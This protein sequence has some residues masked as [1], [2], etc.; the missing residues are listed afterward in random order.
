MPKRRDSLSRFL[1]KCAVKAAFVYICVGVR[2]KAVKDTWAR[3][4]VKV[5]AEHSI[6]NGQRVKKKKKKKKVPDGVL[7]VA[8][9]RPIPEGAAEPRGAAFRLRLTSP[10]HREPRCPLVCLQN[11]PST[12]KNK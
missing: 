5:R 9:L 10:V 3:G 1:Q 4:G 8:G 6:K 11:Q 7:G 2:R 12:T